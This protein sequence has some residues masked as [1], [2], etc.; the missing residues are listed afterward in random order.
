LRPEPESRQVTDWTCPD[1]PPSNSSEHEPPDVLFSTEREN[2]ST[3]S[4][5][6]LASLDSSQIGPHGIY[7]IEVFDIALDSSKKAAVDDFLWFKY[8][9]IPAPKQLKEV[10]SASGTQEPNV[11]SLPKLEPNTARIYFTHNIQDINRMG[12]PNNAI[13]AI[14]NDKRS[15]EDVV[16]GKHSAVDDPFEPPLPWE[17]GRRLAEY[18]P[19]N[20]RGINELC[21]SPN[22]KGLRFSTMRHS[23]EYDNYINDN[24]VFGD[25]LQAPILE[26]NL[27]WTSFALMEGNSLIVLCSTCLPPVDNAEGWY[28]WVQKQISNAASGESNRLMHSSTSATATDDSLFK[29]LCSTFFT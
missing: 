8:A 26:P 29:C 6:G 24:G 25:T 27:S 19:L 18:A 17:S 15:L 9:E 23:H 21:Q 4:V 28:A 1:L 7:S 13:D 2:S 11:L 3:G 22:G 5:S 12:L 20:L 10:E 14:Q 16:D